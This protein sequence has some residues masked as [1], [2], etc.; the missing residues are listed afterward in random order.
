MFP[1]QKEIMSV[2][3]TF[4]TMAAKLNKGLG[5]LR[6]ERDEIDRQIYVLHADKDH[7]CNA[8]DEGQNL[9]EKITPFL[10]TPVEEST[11]QDIAQ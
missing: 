7:V 3:K 6:H 5:K 8:I 10:V 4:E 9:L 1:G 11:K 2:K